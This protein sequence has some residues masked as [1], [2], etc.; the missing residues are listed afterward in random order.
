M[1]VKSPL[2]LNTD[3]WIKAIGCKTVK[4]RRSCPKKLVKRA[5]DSWPYN[6]G[7]TVSKRCEYPVCN[8][9]FTPALR[10]ALEGR[11]RTKYPKSTWDRKRCCSSSCAGLN[12]RLNSKKWNK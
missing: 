6:E 8:K 1:A 11:T 12:R 2:T 4:G 10:V 5:L 9:V 3:A 7:L